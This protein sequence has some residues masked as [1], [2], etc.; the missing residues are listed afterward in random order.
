MPQRNFTERTRAEK[1][2]KESQQ[3]LD[4]ALQAGKIGLWEWNIETNAV[5]FSPEWKRQLGYQDQELRSRFGEWEE[6]LHPEDRN[7]TLA[8]LK[9][10]VEGRRPDYEVEY[11]L[12]HKDG[13][14]RWIFARA[15]LEARPDGKPYRM[16]GCHL[17]ITE[18]KRMEKERAQLLI[19][20][21]T[22]RLE[23]DAARQQLGN[24]LE[25]VSDAFVALDKN[26]RY[27]YVNQQAAHLF[28]RS[29]EHLVGKQI[30]TEF[31]EGLGQPFQ[32]A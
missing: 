12:R 1:M 8:V 6:R 7:S 5:Y 31:P 9:A 17:D 24:I 23:A 28:G 29:P 22:A 21:Q 27:T 30:W 16:A 25:S 20:E 32:R 14:Y 10:Y 3:Y 15:L 4:R 2:V 13:S 11:R 26:W 18:H 19:G